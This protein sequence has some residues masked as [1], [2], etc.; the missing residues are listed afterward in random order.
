ME[1]YTIKKTPEISIILPCLDEEKA[2]GLCLSEI[3]KTIELKKINAE[4]I[5][6]DNGSKDKSRDIV[7]DYQRKHPFIFIFLEKLKGYGS[8]YLTGIKEARGKYVYMADADYTYDFSEIPEFWDTIKEEKADLV[9][10]N[11]FS[12]MME[13]KSMPWLHRYVGNPVFSFL[14][15][16]LFLINLKDVH[17][18]ARLFKKDEIGFLD[19]KSTGMEFSMEM[20]LV[21]QKYGFK[22]VEI[23]IKYRKRIGLSKLKSFSDGWRYLR[24]M[25]SFFLREIKWIKK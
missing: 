23:P 11:R 6:V 24:F 10:G 19:L 16:R 9:I 1:N 4:I 3:I 18:G 15:R 14:A 20:V 17:C 7:R 5:I 13:N 12:G 22:I 8:A 2:I 25:L 21:A